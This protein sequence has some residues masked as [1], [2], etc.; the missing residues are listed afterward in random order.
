[1]FVVSKNS[2]IVIFIK[3]RDDQLP[4]HRMS[5][6]LGQSRISDT[7]HYLVLVRGLPVQFAHTCEQELMTYFEQGFLRVQSGTRANWFD[8]DGQTVGGVSLIFIPHVQL[9]K[10]IEME[11]LDFFNT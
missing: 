5:F 10:Y 1:M 3:H 9:K 4:L 11:I 6:F 8:L 2:R 7:H